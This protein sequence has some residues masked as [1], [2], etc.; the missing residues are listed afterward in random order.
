MKN[1]L[2]FALIICLTHSFSFS[3]NRIVNVV[4]KKSKHAFSSTRTFSS[5][6]I[7]EKVNILRHLL[8]QE[9]KSDIK[10]QI[11]TLKEKEK[12]FKPSNKDHLFSPWRSEYTIKALESSSQK[13]TEQPCPF[14]SHYKQSEDDANYILKRFN[15]CMIMLNLYPYTTGHLLIVP[16]EHCSSLEQLS[17]DAREEIMEVKS[18]CIP[19]LKKAL[20]NQGFNIGINLGDNGASGG[21]IPGHLHV[22]IVPRWVGDTSYITVLANTQIIGTNLNSLYEYLK[23]YFDN[24][25][26]EAT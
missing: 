13:K 25:N 8:E 20:G 15:H 3:M 4:L 14:C 18:I 2:H 6:K 23:P 16:N 5:R 11:K 9:K 21:S 7:N 26:I 24:I 1:E 17:R 10:K 12:N 22:H 19:L